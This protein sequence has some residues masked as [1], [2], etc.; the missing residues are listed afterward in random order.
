M[1]S[2][3]MYRQYPGKTTYTSYANTTINFTNSNKKYSN[4]YRNT[5]YTNAGTKK[6]HTNITYYLGLQITTGDW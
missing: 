5:P 4:S 3:I 2:T 6:T 1:S